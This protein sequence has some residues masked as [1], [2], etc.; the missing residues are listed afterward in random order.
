MTFPNAII[1]LAKRDKG[2]TGEEICELGQEY[3]YPRQVSLLFANSMRDNRILW[4]CK[5]KR[6]GK[7]VRG[8]IVSPLRKN[9][10]GKSK[11]VNS[12]DVG[13]SEKP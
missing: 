9:L 11:P 13:L 10:A 5:L 4:A 2:V 8:W 3:G 6:R 7:V 1:K 12:G